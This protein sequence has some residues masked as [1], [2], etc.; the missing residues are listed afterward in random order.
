[1]VRPHIL[2]ALLYKEYLRYRYNWG[3]LAVVAALLA[4]SALVSVGSRSAA[5]QVLGAAELKTCL[6]F[7][8][9]GT[10]GEAW[11]WHLA[12]RPPPAGVTVVPLGDRRRDPPALET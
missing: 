2:R 10:R 4:L 8:Q 11:A 9:P 12:T 1:M 7:Y 6:L 3:L 5:G